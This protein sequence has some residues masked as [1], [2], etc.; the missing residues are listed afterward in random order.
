[1]ATATLR[2]EVRNTR[3]K[4]QKNQDEVQNTQLVGGHSRHRDV[5]VGDTERMMSALG[6]GAMALY[7]L[8]RG[9]LG[10][11]MLAL[12]GGMLIYRGMTGHC[13]V[14]GTLGVNTADEH[15]SATS[16]A[17]G[18]GVKVDRSIT[19]DAPARKL[20]QTWRKLEN[21]PSFMSH[22]E[23]VTED[24][25]VSHWVA[26]GPMGMRVE[27]DAEIINDSE[28]ELIAWKS[29]EG[30]TV[31]NA[32]SV[33]FT[34]APGG[35]GT[36]V[37]V[38]LKYDP[39]MGKAGAFLAKMFRRAPEQ[40]IKDELRRFKQLMETGEIATTQGQSTCRG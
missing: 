15:G 1:M 38:I 21:L 40:E 27:W 33:H 16:V 2:N 3:N 9:G 18:H 25:D 32:G 12:G 22:L 11:L 39:P 6:G 29:L 31:D 35:R 23:S 5:N 37:R 26:K 20:Y 8:G 28:N 7:G 17:A 4:D 10:G 30:S 36:Q 19:I 34:P 24:G 14:Y 13:S